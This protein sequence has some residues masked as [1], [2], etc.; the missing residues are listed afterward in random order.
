MGIDFLL[1]KR[2]NNHELSMSYSLAKSD[3]RFSNGFRTTQYRLAPQSQKHEL[4][5]AAIFNFKP[6]RFSLTNVY[7]SG[8]SNFTFRRSRE[9]FI[10]YWRTDIALQYQFHIASQSVEAGLSIL[11]LF[12][13]RNVRLNQSVNVP[14][15]DIINTAGIPFSS[16]VY[17]SVNF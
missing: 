8:F 16:T 7:G 9:E 2:L 11:N 10:P 12:N 6:F 14:D 13:R 4:K 5:A 17:L 3:E 1:R 15:G